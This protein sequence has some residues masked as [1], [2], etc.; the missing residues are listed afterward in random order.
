MSKN[1]ILY[2][3]VSSDEQKDNT[4]LDYQEKTLR[5][6]CETNDYNVIECYKEDFSA[7]HYNFK[8]PEM[9]RLKE[10]C[11]KH[12]SEVNII[13]FLRWDRFSRNSEFAH[14][15]KRIFYDDWGIEFNAVETPIDFE[16]TDWSFLLSAYCGIAQ[17]ENNKISRRT[18]D[19]I[20]ETKLAGRW[21]NQAPRGYKNVHITDANGMVIAKTVEIDEATAPQIRMVFEEVAKGVETP[22][23]IRRRM[24]NI[25]ESSFFQMLRNIFYI[26]KIRVG[27]T[28]TEPER[29][30]NGIHEPLIPEHIFYRVQDILDGKAK[31]AP[32][33]CKPIEPE[34]YLRKFL[35]CPVCG[36]GITGAYS[37]GQCGTRYPY[38]FCCEDGKHIRMKAEQVNDGFV[39]YVGSLRPH[40]AVLQLYLEILNDLRKDNSR[41]IDKE[42][43]KL[44]Q[45][46]YETNLRIDK[47]EDKYL[48]G[49]IGRDEYNRMISRHKD[50]IKAL[51]DK[52]DILRAPNRSKIEPQLRYSINLIANMDKFFATAPADAK[53]KVLSSIFPE[54]IEFDGKKYR[55]FSYNKV[56][57]LI[58]RQTNE[59]RGEQKENGEDF[60][61]F[62]VTVPRAGVEPAQG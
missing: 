13:L 18:K 22:S 52:I 62:S 14:K 36:H 40:E 31:K 45:D 8:R 55:T 35:K 60:S 43:Q 17:T 26:G 47:I 37:R 16:G 10:Y 53:I 29:I 25:A 44:E 12:K 51:Q 56:L 34:L 42:V 11:S 2:C 3:R 30:V 28:K 15:F 48:D 4:S 23:C 24:T 59:L 9:K 27:A 7:K 1:A 33:L 6:Y 21:P 50:G 57:D 58:Y 61:S 38:Y 39:R 41:E 54:K 20:R 46:K 49:E 19:G 5:H 32:K